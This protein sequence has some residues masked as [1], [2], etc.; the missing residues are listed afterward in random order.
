MGPVLS[1]HRSRREPA[2]SSSCHRASS[3]LT[4]CVVSPSLSSW[5]CSCRSRLA[6][7]ACPPPAR[8]RR[9]R[10]IGRAP[11]RP[12]H[13]SRLRHRP[14]R[15]VL[16]SVGALCTVCAVLFPFLGSE[17]IPDLSE[18]AIAASVFFPPST[19]L[20]QTLKR[21]GEVER[22]LRE[23]FPDEVDHVVSRV[24]RAEVATDPMLPSQADVFVALRPSKQWRQA[25]TQAELLESV[26][27]VFESVPGMAMSYTQPI[28]MRMMEMIE[29]QGMR[30]DPGIFST[31]RCGTRRG[32]VWSACASKR[33][34]PHGFALLWRI[35]VRACLSKSGSASSNGFIA[36]TRH[37]HAPWV[38]RGW[39]LP[40]CV[41]SS[42][43]TGGVFTSRAGS[44]EAPASSAFSR[45]KPE[46]RGSRGP[47]LRA[48]GRTD[49]EA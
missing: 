30:S 11:T 36:S 21:C 42:R 31:T 18:G 44:G 22:L 35:R 16:A 29:G 13:A 33:R 4:P 10:P 43:P 27:K 20:E 9:P 45:G 12:A 48:R 24:G 15:A 26:A 34:T 3:R 28:K 25:R 40:S 7:A 32:E 49:S 46:R 38:E 23:R 14:G 2:S 37:G 41:A 47:L 39:A 6:S 5:R 19:P 8:G 17:F 1:D